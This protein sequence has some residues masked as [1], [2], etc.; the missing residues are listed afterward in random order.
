MRLKEAGFFDV[1]QN[2]GCENT[3]VVSIHN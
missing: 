2:N 3:Y 1:E